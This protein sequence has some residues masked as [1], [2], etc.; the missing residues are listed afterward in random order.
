MEDGIK[1]S[2][3]NQTTKANNE[4][5]IPIVQEEETKNITIRDFAPSVNNYSTDE[6]VIGKWT[7]GKPIYRKVISVSGTMTTG[8]WTNVA[9]ASN[10]ETLV[11]G[12][13]FDASTEKRMWSDT[14]I[15]VTST[16]FQYFSPTYAHHY[17]FLIVEY[18][19]TTD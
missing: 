10:I 13:L 14:M 4:D 15:G 1:I 16:N 6:I 8:Q 9:S 11:Y 3:L 19:K 18:T 7:D 2:E 17:N 12:M 5:L